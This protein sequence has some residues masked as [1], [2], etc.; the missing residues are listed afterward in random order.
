MLF[1][2]RPKGALE[3]FASP[4]GDGEVLNISFNY[5]KRSEIACQAQTLS[6]PVYVQVFVQG[7]TVPTSDFAVSNIVIDPTGTK[8]LFTL[9]N[10]SAVP[11]QIYELYAKVAFSGGNQLLQGLD[12]EVSVPIGGMVVPCACT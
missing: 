11:E 2:I 4:A 12:I 5:R 10:V 1:N 3:T 6:A 8:L 7:Q 9:T